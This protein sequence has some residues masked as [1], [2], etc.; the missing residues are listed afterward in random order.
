MFL[1]IITP[2]SRPKNLKAIAKS[3][4]LPAHAYRWLVI[5]DAEEIPENIPVEC[6]AYAI[7]VKDSV[8]GNGQRNAG[9]DLVQEGH[10]YF[11]DDDT[12][13]HEELWDNIKNLEEDFISFE[14]ANKDGSIRLD[15]K[16]ISVGHVD[17]HNFIVSKKCVG[18]IKWPISRYDADGVFAYE[19]F[20]NAETQKHIPK[21]LSIYNS[22][23]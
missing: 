13:I 19:C 6:E 11:N 20:N 3:I 5:F 7:K 4:N 14:Q 2:C 8:F 22:L 16:T 18:D 1:N 23:K 12:E 9:L 15:G 21:T 17:S 10:I